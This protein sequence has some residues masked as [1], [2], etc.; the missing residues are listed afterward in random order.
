MQPTLVLGDATELVEQ[1]GLAD[2]PKHG[3]PAL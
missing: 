3:E 2:V 1:H